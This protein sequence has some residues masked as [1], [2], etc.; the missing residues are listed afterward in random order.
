MTIIFQKFFFYLP[1]QRNRTS[2]RSKRPVAKQQGYSESV[3]AESVF[4]D[5]A[6]FKILLMKEIT[7]D[8][9]L[10][11]SYRLCVLVTLCGTQ[12]DHKMFRDFLF[13]SWY[14]Y[15]RLYSHYLL[16]S[17]NNKSNKPG[18]QSFTIHMGIEWEQKYEIQEWE[19]II[20]SH[21][22]GVFPQVY[23]YLLYVA[24]RKFHSGEKLEYHICI[25]C[26]IPHCLCP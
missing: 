19:Q 10:S 18:A 16:S 5:T 25:S 2:K 6:R 9:F 8:S 3:H 12:G 14:W 21:I 24:L 15:S 17:L 23:S 26:T 1:R 22:L 20:S 13:I 11:I 4:C 7:A